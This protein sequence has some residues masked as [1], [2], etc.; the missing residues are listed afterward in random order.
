MT[1]DSIESVRIVTSGEYELNLDS[2]FKKE[3]IILGIRDGE[4][5]IVPLTT[6]FETHSKNKEKKKETKQ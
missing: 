2:L 3:D 4:R 5:Y 6:V 1:P